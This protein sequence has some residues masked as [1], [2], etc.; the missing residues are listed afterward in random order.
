MSTSRPPG[1]PP[2]PGG[3]AAAALGAAA[4]WGGMYVVSKDTFSDVPPITL[5][6]L[7]LAIAAPVL[8]LVLA[9]GGR[10][11]V[12]RDPVL[13]LAGVLLAGTMVTQFVGTDLATASQGALLTTTT[14]LF[15]V[16][17]GWAFL[18]E[19]PGTA[20]V[21]GIAVGLAGV[22]L[23]VGGVTGAYRSPW[24]PVLLLVSA[25]GWAGYTIASAP[26]ARRQGPLTAVTWA[27]VVALPVL[28]LLSLFEVDRWHAAA[29]TRP[30][31]L[32]AIAYLGLAASAGAWY[33]WNR[34]VAGLPAAVAGAFF[35]IQPVVGG[36]L[37]RVVLGEGLGLSFAAGGL[38]ILTG[39]LLAMRTP[40]ARGPT[41]S[42]REHRPEPSSIGKERP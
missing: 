29:F 35:F 25:A 17:F 26:T 30:V 18:R 7:R 15:L 8:A 9:V 42:T 11:R 2:F 37:A 22:A 13:L 32:G 27:T 12:P 23:A 1:P 24:G 28:A 4:L 20:T 16:P 5:G 6:A 39:V 34:G 40:T 41:R 38:L 3:A 36:I 21:A 14:P 33:L 19:R 31:T 10:P